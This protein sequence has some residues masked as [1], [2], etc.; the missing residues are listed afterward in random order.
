MPR[1][2]SIEEI[3]RFQGS[4]VWNYLSSI[5][6]IRPENL[7]ILDFGT[8]DCSEEIVCQDEESGLIF[9]P[10]SSFDTSSYATDAARPEEDGNWF[11]AQRMDSDT[12]RRLEQLRQFIL[13]KYVVDFGCGRGQFL[14]AVSGIAK[15]AAGIE[16]VPKLRKA[17]AEDGLV[18]TPR[19][20]D[21]GTLGD[22]WSQHIDSVF[23]FHV[24]EHLENPIRELREI[25]SRM[26]SSGHIIIEV[27]HA[28]SLL[29]ELSSE[30]LRFS[31]W[32]QHLVLHTRWTLERTLVEAGF[33]TVRILGIQRYP[34]SNALGW[35]AQRRGGG[36]LSDLSVIDT[37]DLSTAWADALS[38][39]DRSDTLLAVAR[40]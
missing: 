19:L 22:E 34:I 12:T 24:L 16:P 1:A 17:L 10:E 3:E 28:N 23:L 7:K 2:L 6:A 18:V 29:S 38:R 32:S 20:A 33:T 31:L 39:L 26:S 40:V 25:R 9:L 27:P 14:R 13:G 21:L 4:T 36:H 11:T 15:R 5:G 35:L 8:R 37:Q 30:F